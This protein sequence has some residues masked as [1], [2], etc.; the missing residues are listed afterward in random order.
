[1]S[2]ADTEGCLTINVRGSVI[3]LRVFMENFLWITDKESRLIPFRLNFEQETV[4]RK[5]CE[6]HSRGE[7]MSI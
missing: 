4:Y 3:D 5:M 6:L 2:L 7:M 1:M